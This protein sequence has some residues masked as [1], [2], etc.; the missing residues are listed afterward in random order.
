M[1]FTLDESFK[2]LFASTNLRTEQSFS[3]QEE[4]QKRENA[5]ER[6]KEK[7]CDKIIVFSVARN[8]SF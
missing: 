8:V 2:K 7:A 4:K 6:L 5:K 1:N 3:P